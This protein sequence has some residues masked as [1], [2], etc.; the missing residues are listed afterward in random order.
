MVRG[1]LLQGRFR[2]WRR[3]EFPRERV[4]WLLHRRCVVRPRGIARMWLQWVD[5]RRVG[6]RRALWGWGCGVLQDP[7][8]LCR[9]RL[10]RTLSRD[11]DIWSHFRDWSRRAEKVRVLQ[12]SI[13]QSV[14]RQ[15]RRR[16]CICLWCLDRRCLL[17]L[18]RPFFPWDALSRS[19]W[20]YR[21]LWRGHVRLMWLV[22]NMSVLRGPWAMC[23]KSWVLF[24][25][26]LCRAVF[27]R[28]RLCY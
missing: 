11:N 5:R 24:H 1:G 16:A 2:R 19:Q 12:V 6:R 9:R 7:Q 21:G 3:H 27:T 18:A 4:C 22:L 15:L 20:A 23:C 14:G 10:S 25:R 13:W 28:K 26:G 8:G 17:D